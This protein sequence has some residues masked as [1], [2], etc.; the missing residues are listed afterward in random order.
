VFGKSTSLMDERVD[1]VATQ[2]GEQRLTPTVEGLLLELGDKN[3]TLPT[4]NAMGQ[5]IAN[6]SAAEKTFVI[7]EMAQ[8][9]AVFSVFDI[10]AFFAVL[11]VGFAYVWKRGDLD[12]VRAITR[13][14]TGQVERLPSPDTIEDEQV[15][16]A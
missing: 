11:M 16:T 12:W 2:A 8:T 5:D 7:R 4:T 14:R 6:A 10:A 9:M 15:L 3:P 13:Q 1:V